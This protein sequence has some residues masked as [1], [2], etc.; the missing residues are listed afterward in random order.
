MDP[1]RF[2]IPLGAVLLVA[3]SPLTD[4]GDPAAETARPYVEAAAAPPVRTGR[5]AI[6][7]A[8]V[9]AR[10][11][12]RSDRFEGGVQVF[13]WSPG[14]VYEVWTAPLRVTT[15]TLAE[16]ETL[17]AKAAGDTVRWQVGE[18]SSGE[19][20]TG[21]THVLLKPLQR[22][23]ETNLV[24][25]TD[26]RVYLIALKSG[27]PEAFNPAIAWDT[28][29]AAAASD[30][31]EPAPVPEVGPVRPEGPLNAR[32]AIEGRRTAWTPTAV[33][34]DGRRTFIAFGPGLEAVEA[35]A[36]FVIGPDGQA[37]YVN[38]RQYRGLFIADRVFDRA[39]LRIGERRPQVVR[40]RRLEGERP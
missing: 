20:G 9:E 25:T 29:P 8:N 12:S 1:R 18:A 37:Q 38:Y 13:A 24:L 15:L 34:D 2:M 7:D 35:P 21:R 30:P 3:W 16:G 28:P 22:G 6:A 31:I 27:A 10:A 11:A 32:Y 23:L 5:R 39:E 14:R 17:I 40:I 19:A 36:L 33:F 26:R 4:P